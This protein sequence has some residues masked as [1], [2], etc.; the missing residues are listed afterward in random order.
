M[1]RKLTQTSDCELTQNQ[2]DD[3][4]DES[5]G[6]WTLNT[7]FIEDDLENDI[8]LI[9]DCASVGDTIMFDVATT[10]QPESTIA[11]TTAD[12]TFTGY[13]DDTTIKDEIFPES[14]SKVTFTC[15][16]NKSIFDIQYYLFYTYI[17]LTIYL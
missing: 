12:L 4:Y 6:I 15:P 7:E 2:I 14:D 3:V 8:Q 17:Y 9:V 11:V 1:L 5:N 13:T 16:E 10:I